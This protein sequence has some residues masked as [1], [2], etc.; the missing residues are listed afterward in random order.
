MSMTRNLERLGLEA[1]AEALDPGPM[2]VPDLAFAFVRQY[3]G[4]VRMA[5]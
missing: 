1:I 4:F 5:G 3:A 2:T